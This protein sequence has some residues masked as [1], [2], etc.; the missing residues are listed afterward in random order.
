MNNKIFNSYLYIICFFSQD[1]VCV[2]IETKK[3]TSQHSLKKPLNHYKS[4]RGK[5]II[6]NSTILFEIIQ[7]IAFIDIN[8]ESINFNIYIFDFHTHVKYDSKTEV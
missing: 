6:M 3:S 8:N 4:V 7:L 5:Y 2:E 1:E